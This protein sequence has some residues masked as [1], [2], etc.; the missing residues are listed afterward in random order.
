MEVPFFGL[1]IQQHQ[2]EEIQDEDRPSIDDNLHRPEKFGV[3]EDKE[4]RNV[5][6]EGQESQAAVHGVAQRH[7]ED[8]CSNT[9]E[10]KVGKE[11]NGHRGFSSSVWG[12]VGLL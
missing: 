8:P 1:E 6:Q 9:H 4:P 11:D 3:Q 5:E 12:P 2:D 7:R 10:R